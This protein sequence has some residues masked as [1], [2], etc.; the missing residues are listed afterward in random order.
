VVVGVTGGIAAYKAC[1]LVSALVKAGAEVRVVM[2]RNAERF[3]SSLTFATLSGSPTYDDM[4]APRTGMGHISLA[5]FAEVAIIAPATAN[6]IGKHAHGIAD[7]LL[8]TALLAFTCPV[9]V[10]PSMNSRMLR[11]DAVNENL[12]TLRRRGAGIVEPEEGRLA[13]GDEGV[14]RLPATDVLLAAIVEALGAAHGPLAGVRVLVTAGPTREPMDPVRFISNPSSGKMGYAVATEAARQGADATLVSGPVALG[15]P[16]GVEVVRVTTAQQMHEAVKEREGAVDVFVGAAAV[17]D[18]RPAEPGDQKLKKSGLDELTVRLERTPDIIAAVARW[19]PKPV[20]VGFAA[21]TEDLLRHA[22]EKLRDKGLDL[23][24]ANDV[25]R[26]DAGFAVDANQIT[27]IGTSGTQT[28]FPMMSKAE[29]AAAI[30]DRVQELL[31]DR[32]QGGA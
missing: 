22:D 1:D 5:D 9:I 21:E 8:S 31:A 32:R 4:W 25:G 30:L 20:V 29:V 28:E 14:G 26:L 11:S 23:I 16:P 2:T 3:V 24:A 10:A 13:C 19:E 18:W 7:D 6:I 17:A 15:D 27:L 12:E